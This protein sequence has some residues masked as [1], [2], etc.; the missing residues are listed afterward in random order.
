M[1]PMGPVMGLIWLV[2]LACIVAAVVWLVRG[3]SWERG[4]RW[5]SFRPFQESPED[6]LRRRFAAGEIDEN[7]FRRRLE[8]LRGGQSFGTGGA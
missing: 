2:M 7:E 8:T 4:G 6:I 5:T 1:G 3:V